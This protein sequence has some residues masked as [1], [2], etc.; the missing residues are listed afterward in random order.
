MEGAY[1]LKLFVSIVKNKL[2]LKSSLAF[3]RDTRTDSSMCAT[4]HQTIYYQCMKSSNYILAHENLPMQ[5]I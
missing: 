3:L 5:H 4:M 1:S 2:H